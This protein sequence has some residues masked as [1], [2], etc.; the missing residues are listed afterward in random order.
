MNMMLYVLSYL[1]LGYSTFDGFC[2]VSRLFDVKGVTC[3]PM[4]SMRRQWTNQT[5][6]HQRLL[7]LILDPSQF[8]MDPHTSIPGKIRFF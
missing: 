2:V 1:V 8:F 3:Y 6:H 4:R 7:H 5:N